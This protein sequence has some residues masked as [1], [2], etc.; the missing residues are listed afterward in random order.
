MKRKTLLICLWRQYF[1]KYCQ[2]N[3]IKEFRLSDI[4]TSFFDYCKG[5]KLPVNWKSFPYQLYKIVVSLYSRGDLI[6]EKRGEYKFR[7]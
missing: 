1:T 5:E 7:R 6:R 4:R 2:E 3:H